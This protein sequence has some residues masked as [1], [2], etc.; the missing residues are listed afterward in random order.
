VNSAI[1]TEYDSGVVLATIIESNAEVCAVCV[2]K[3]P[4]AKLNELIS[5]LDVR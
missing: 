4:F 5:N 2:T 1:R 3:T